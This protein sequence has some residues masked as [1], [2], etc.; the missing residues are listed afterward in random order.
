MWDFLENR[1]QLEVWQEY[2]FVKTL[3]FQNRFLEGPFEIKLW[4]ARKAV[5]KINRKY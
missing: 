1:I 5:K 3:F 4:L 2:L